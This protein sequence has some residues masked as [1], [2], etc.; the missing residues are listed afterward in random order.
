VKLVEKWKIGMMNWLYDLYILRCL[1]WLRA[2]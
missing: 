1:V 2:L